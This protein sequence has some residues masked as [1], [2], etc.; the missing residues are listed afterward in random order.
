[1]KIDLSRDRKKG[2]GTIGTFR[3]K[4][5]ARGRSQHEKMPNGLQEKESMQLKV[6]VYLD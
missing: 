1:M 4:T 2:Q 5:K 6:I 3:W